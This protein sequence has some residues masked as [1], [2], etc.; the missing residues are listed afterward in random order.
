[1]KRVYNFSPG[2]AILPESVLQQAQKE[3]LDF[4]GTGMSVMEMSHR[5]ECY[6]AIAEKARDNLRKV[7]SVPDNYHILFLHGGA[8][9]QFSMIPLNCLGTKTTTDYL[10]T[11]MWSGK[12]IEEARRYCNV[13]VAMSCEDSQ[14]MTIP[15]QSTWSL[16]PDAAYVHYTPNETIGGLEFLTMPDFGDVP[17]VADMSSTIL[18]RPID[19]SRFALIYAGAQKNLGPSGITIVIIRDDFVKEPLPATPGLFRYRDQIAQDSMYNTPPTFAWYLVGLVLEWIETTGGLTAMEAKNKRKAAKLYK[20]IDESH[21]YRNRVDPHYRSWMNIPFQLAD[22]KLDALFLKQAEALGLSNLKGHRSVGGMRASIY[23]AMPEEGVDAL[24]T[25]MK[26]F[27][28]E[29]A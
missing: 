7:L 12:A 14:F 9:A 27:E 11:G 18:S 20:A 26:S 16:D 17:V 19:V 25:F 1:M 6:I 13:N 4:Q 29:Q 23:N 8:T 5:S 28:K 10:H 2:P 3:L 21:L 24:V 15:S 22:P